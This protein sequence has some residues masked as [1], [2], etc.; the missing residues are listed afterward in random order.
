MY[1]NILLAYD[2]SQSGQHALLGCRD[3]AQ[4]SQA[5]LSLVA[6]TPLPVQMISMEGGF[7]D[8]SLADIERQKYAAILADGLQQL[9]AAGFEAKG[10]LLLGDTVDEIV[11][12][13]EKINADLIVVGH[14]RRI[15]WAER[16]W[17]GAV[18]KSLIEHAPCSVL[19]VIAH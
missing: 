1:K 6:V 7:Y 18:S 12:C 14:Q 3:I 5:A 4:W 16:W 11:R 17:R 19:V 15:S 2:G 9:A 8:P 10:E 13:A